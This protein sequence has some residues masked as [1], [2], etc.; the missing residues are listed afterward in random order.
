MNPMDD[1]A[2]SGLTFAVKGG[3]CLHDEEEEDV[4]APPPPPQPQTQNKTQPKT[5]Y[6]NDKKEAEVSARHILRS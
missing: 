4:P 5:Q 6:A 2:G 1:T 3:M